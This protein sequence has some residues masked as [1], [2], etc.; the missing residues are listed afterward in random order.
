M[1][2]VITDKPGYSYDIHSL[3]KA[4]FPA[5]DVFVFE[6]RMPE[7][8]EEK[9]I[10]VSIPE[11]DDRIAV[12]NRI[13]QELYR[14]LSGE[15]GRRLPWGSLTGIRPVK[16]PMGFLA[17]G[18]GEEEIASYM[19]KTY[20]CSREKIA[21]A[22]EIAKREL[23]VI[24]R[25]EKENGY[26]LYVGIPFCPTTCAY[27]SFASY[28]L[29]R[30][31]D[32]KEDY[33]KAL[34]QELSSVSELFSDRPLLTVYVGGGTPTALEAE[35]LDRLLRTLWNLFPM[36]EAL[37][38]TV[39]AGRPD[40]ITKE[41]LA[42]L[43]EHGVTRISVNPQTFSQK[44]L[45]L[46]GRRHTVEQTVESYAL[47]R[48]MGFTNINMDLIMGLPGEIEEDVLHTLEEVKRL[49]PEDITVHSLA[50]KRASRLKIEWDSYR[51]F[52]MKNTDA[53]M[54]LT[55]A[56]C[57]ELGRLPYYLYRQK[58]MAGNFENVGYAAPGKEGLYNIFMMEEVGDIAACGAGTVS[59]RVFADG[60]I[61]R[62]DTVKDLDL[63]ISRIDEMVE[64]KRKLFEG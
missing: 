17:D 12:K 48:N 33:L 61:E 40:S 24:R 54:K 14:R 44:T 27:C 42:V 50:L 25:L 32:R 47:A 58:N 1:I 5:E 31:S 2:Q 55:E 43:K 38:L 35:E 15:T 63:Y 16:I 46:I 37:E 9:Q 36:K 8:K 57:R 23:S 56:A 45:D 21:L 49:A 52:Q 41:K 51:A 62:C 28:P 10:Y 20:F 22:T 11:G 34:F 30:F 3:V 19:E 29:E 18:R 53:Q 59:K 39:E 4:F 26:S 7:S 13:K 6:G 64:R 60:R